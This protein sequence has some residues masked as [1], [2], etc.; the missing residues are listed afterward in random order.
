MTTAQLLALLGGIGTAMTAIL[1]LLTFVLWQV[2]KGRAEA[3]MAELAAGRSE[4]IAPLETLAAEG[5]AVTR[6]STAVRTTVGSLTSRVLELE[7][8]LLVAVDQ[9]NAKSAEVV[10]TGARE[11]AALEKL[12]EC[13]L[14]KSDYQKHVKQLHDEIAMMTERLEQMEA[15]QGDLPARFAEQVAKDPPR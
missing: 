5:D 13:V 6:W 2:K 15:R 12:R 9:L 11:A 1:A 8:R 3:R 7:E 4:I 14:E 10:A